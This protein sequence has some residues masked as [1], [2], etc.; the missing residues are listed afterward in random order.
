MSDISTIPSRPPAKDRAGLRL[1]FSTRTGTA[2]LVCTLMS[3]AFPAS[4]QYR[5]HNLVSDKAGLALHTDGNL[6]DP[7]GMAALPGGGFVVADALSGFVTFYS[8]QGGKLRAPVTVPPAPSLPPGT[9]GSPAGLVANPTSEFVISK[10]GKSAP[11]LYLFSTLDG[12]ICGWNPAVDPDNAVI[13]LDNSTLSPFPAS[14]TDL[15]MARNRFGQMVIYASD[16]GV[17]A[18]QSNNDVEI[19]DGHFHLLRRFTDHSVR[20]D[21]TV[22]SARIVGEKVY[23][24]FGGFTPLDGGVVDV[25]DTEGNMLRRFASSPPGGTLE[26][27]WEVVLA[28]DGFGWASHRLLIGE[29]DSGEISVFDPESGVFLGP[30]ADSH[31]KPIVIDG[32]W[33]LIFT[34]GEVENNQNDLP[35]RLFFAAGCAFPPDYSP[36]LFG[37]ISLESAGDDSQQDAPSQSLPLI[38]HKTRITR[39][40]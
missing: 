16:S 20:S 3:G 19:Y 10:N 30:L 33:A 22:Y 21:L 6:L 24:T 39:K 17:S 13:I 27:P 18:T 37:Y 11:A 35:L 2:V 25:F 29:V 4:A 31:G 40:D 14:Y 15:T 12:L 7:W 1:G 26:A 36:S 8:A 9:P 5:Q 34:G 38:R 32:V 28:P 23:V